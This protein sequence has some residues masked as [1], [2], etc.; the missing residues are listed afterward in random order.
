MAELLEQTLQGG[1]DLDLGQ[2]V[3]GA[4]SVLTLKAGVRNNWNTTSNWTGN[5]YIAWRGCFWYVS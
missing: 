2:T 4:S 3:S 1:I 5:Y